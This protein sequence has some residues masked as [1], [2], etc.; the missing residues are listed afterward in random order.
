MPQGSL[1][2]EGNGTGFDNVGS[3]LDTVRLEEVI[4]VREGVAL[5]VGG[6]CKEVI[7]GIPVEDGIR[8]RHARVHLWA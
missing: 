7:V 5:L 8:R 3:Y 6:R 4:E 1:P 2:L